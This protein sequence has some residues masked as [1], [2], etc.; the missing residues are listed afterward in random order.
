MTLKTLTTAA[1]MFSLAACGAPE[2][3]DDV[4]APEQQQ[5]LGAA[6][7]QKGNEKTDKEETTPLPVAPPAG[8]VV[9]N[10]TGTES[11]EQEEEYM[12]V[13]VTDGTPVVEE[14]PVDEQPVVEETPVEEDETPEAPAAAFA[15]AT[16]ASTSSPSFTNH[17]F[18]AN[19]ADVYIALDI[20][21]Q[22][23]G[24]HHT[25]TVFVNMPGGYAYQAFDVAFAT[26]AAA[27]G[28]E[29]QAEPT[30]TGYRI[31]ITLPV[32]GTWIEQFQLGGEWSAE[33]YVDSAM[34]ADATV[35]FTLE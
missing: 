14:P 9:A 31:W 6:K 17:F 23:T 16:S 8:P 30:A 28:N 3:T 1:L 22:V 12:P 19:T 7:S 10:P 20:G 4:A 11:T 35:A 13:D 15:L 34:T 21:A 25:A 33:A 27:V 32:A 24:G 26:D 18:I 5:S 29:L 2:Q